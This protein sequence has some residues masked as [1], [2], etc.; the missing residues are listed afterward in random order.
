M[1]K[2]ESCISFQVEVVVVEVRPREW[3]AE[4]TEQP[5]VQATRMGIDDRWEATTR[6]GISNAAGLGAEEFQ[7]PGLRCGVST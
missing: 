5:A 4:L 2:G 7:C 1:L 3:D 6:T